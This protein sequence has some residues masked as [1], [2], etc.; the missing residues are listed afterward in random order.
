MFTSS[1]KAEDVCSFNKVASHG[2]GPITEGGNAGGNDA[3]FLQNNEKE[4][5]PLL[6]SPGTEIFVSHS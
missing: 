2:A 1:T 3:V 6:R 5:Q 4:Q